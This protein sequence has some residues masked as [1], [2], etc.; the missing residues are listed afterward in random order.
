MPPRGCTTIC[1]W[2]SAVSSRSWAV[3][4]GLVVQLASLPVLI[5]ARRHE[6]SAH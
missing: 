3:T 4:K 5:F 2:S 6:R 1:G